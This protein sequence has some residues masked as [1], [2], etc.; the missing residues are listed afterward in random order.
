[1]TP[2]PLLTYTPDPQT[3]YWAARLPL[4]LDLPI[5][6]QYD[7]LDYRMRA[8][9]W[10]KHILATGFPEYCDYPESPGALLASPENVIHCFQ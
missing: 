4:P 7:G 6:P 10:R 1:M 2:I 5:Q 8:E 3:A 9:T